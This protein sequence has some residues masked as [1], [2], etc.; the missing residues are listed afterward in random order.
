MYSLFLDV[1]TQILF[2][3]YDYEYNDTFK[4]SNIRSVDTANQDNGSC[5]TEIIL[6][7]TDQSFIEYT[8][9]TNVYNESFFQHHFN[10]PWLYFR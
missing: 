4:I 7:C 9:S 10:C 5:V 8:D 6:G 3:Y 1:Q 2:R